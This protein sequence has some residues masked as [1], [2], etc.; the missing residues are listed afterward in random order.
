MHKTRKELHFK[1]KKF[2][3][4]FSN[5]GFHLCT[6]KSINKKLTYEKYLQLPESNKKISEMSI[7]KPTKQTSV[8][9]TP[10]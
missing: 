2:S 10:E 9:L 1:Q 5:L 6:K 7:P 3:L 8:N 4:H